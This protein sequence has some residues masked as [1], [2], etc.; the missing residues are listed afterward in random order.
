MKLA[1]LQKAERLRREFDDLGKALAALRNNPKLPTL[2]VHATEFQSGHGVNERRVALRK[3]F[4]MQAIKT[5]LGHIRYELEQL[6]VSME[7]DR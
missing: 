6:G 3:D 4:A 7:T 5:Q 2:T 1:D